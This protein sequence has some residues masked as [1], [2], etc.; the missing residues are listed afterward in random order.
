[1]GKSP[2]RRC[3][4]RSSASASD[5]VNGDRAAPKKFLRPAGTASAA[6]SVVVSACASGAA[7][8]GR[9]RLVKPG[10]RFEL[11][12][13]SVTCDLRHGRGATSDLRHGRGAT[14]WRSSVLSSVIRSYLPAAVVRLVALTCFA[15]LASTGVALADQS[16]ST[17]TVQS[18]GTGSY[19][20][21]TSTDAST[22]TTPKD[23]TSTSRSATDATL[24]RP[25]GLATADPYRSG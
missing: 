8:R 20:G 18:A 4:K 21:T 7:R 3:Q 13:L 22:S 9:V 1:M 24:F 5:V 11:A 10:S 17:P 16:S 15:V 14:K 25:G 19:L 12:Q 2:R 23:A 6:A